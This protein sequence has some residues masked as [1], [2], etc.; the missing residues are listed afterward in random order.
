MKALLRHDWYVYRKRLLILF[1]VYCFLM[2]LIFAGFGYPIKGLAEQQWQYRF[3]LFIVLAPMDLFVGV[4]A[5]NALS[6]DSKSGWLHLVA[7]MPYTRGQIITEKAV[8]GGLVIAAH[9]I[10]VTVCQLIATAGTDGGLA[11]GLE[12]ACWELAKP[13]IL[14]A[15]L[16]VLT[17]RWNQSVAVCILL[18]V[19]I[20]L[21]DLPFMVDWICVQNGGR[22]F[23]SD[24]V[25]RLISFLVTLPGSFVLLVSA[26]LLYV[27]CWRLSV[28]A[29]ARK[30][31]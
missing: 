20:V 23:L 15:L 26:I 27:L 17:V 1:G 31:L 12:V 8:F 5:A 6:H 11:I 7:A 2:G 19:A 29:F 16:F 18:G 30:T 9:G 10:C 22:E 25:S 14:S 24:A 3:I 4:T 21:P 28:R 13:L